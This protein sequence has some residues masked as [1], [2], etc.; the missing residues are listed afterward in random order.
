LCHSCTRNPVEPTGF[1]NRPPEPD[2]YT[3][4]VWSRRYTDFENQATP[5]QFDFEINAG[6]AGSS[7]DGGTATTVA[8]SADI[9][10][11]VFLDVNLEGRW[12]G[13]G[14]GKSSRVIVIFINLYLCIIIS[15]IDVR[16]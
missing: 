10:D 1:C 11:G 9:N 12:Q 4:L 15:V 16:L 14:D 3:F 2:S 13:I 6:I 5:L 8:A 7:E